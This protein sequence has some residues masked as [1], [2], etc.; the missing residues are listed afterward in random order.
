MTEIL[1]IGRDDN[2]EAAVLAALDSVDYTVQRVRT[3]TEANE[4]A[5]KQHFD[6]LIIDFDPY[7]PSSPDIYCLNTGIM[8]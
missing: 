1:F 3:V 7:F 2:A 5:S 8:L 4:L 6:A